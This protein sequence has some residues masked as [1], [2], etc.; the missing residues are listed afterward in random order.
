MSDYGLGT[1]IEV[2]SNA[3]FQRGKSFIKVF[4]IVIE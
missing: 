4:K 1:Q 2:P 3:K